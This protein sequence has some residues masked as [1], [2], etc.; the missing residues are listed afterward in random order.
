MIWGWIKVIKRSRYKSLRKRL[1]LCGGIDGV[2]TDAGTHK[3]PHPGPL[4]DLGPL[5]YYSKPTKPPTVIKAITVINSK[6]VIT[7]SE[8]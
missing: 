3:L 1:T 4:S 6:S 5:I 7:L 2:Q 8:G